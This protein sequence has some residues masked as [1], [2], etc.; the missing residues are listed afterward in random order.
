MKILQRTVIIP[1]VF[2][3]IA[4]CF[5]VSS[6]KAEVLPATNVSSIK[7]ETPPQDMTVSGNIPDPDAAPPDRSFR[8]EM[9]SDISP[10]SEKSTFSAHIEYSPE[11]YIVK[12]TFEEFPPDLNQ[13]LLLYSL[14]GKNWQVCDESWTLPSAEAA[15]G[16][17][18]KKLLDHTC[19]HSNTEPFKS[20]LAQNLDRFY[21]KL[22]YT[23]KDGNTWESREAVI[24]RGG[25]QP[26]PDDF[27][28]AAKFASSLLISERNPIG[29]YGRYQLTV[30]E[31]SLP[32]KI[33]SWLPD[34]LPVEI[35]L[36]QGGLFVT[37]CVIDCPVTWKPLSLPALT[38]G[39]SV[40]IYNAAEKIEIPAGTL[41][42][43]PTGVYRLDKPLH[44]DQFPLTDEVRLVLNVIDKESSPEGVLSIDNYGLT[45]SFHKK[46]T[47][48]T[49]I[50]VYLLT[51]GETEWTELADHSLSEAV[52]A[53]PITPNSGYALVLPDT[54]KPFQ[55][56][57]A[58][59][60]AG[61]APT[62]FYIGL[63]IEGGVYHG[64]ELI[65]PW[66]GTYDSDLL[67]LPNLSGS[68]GN[69]GNAGSDNK[70]DS[71]AEGQRP[72]LP[73]SPELQPTGSSDN[74]ADDGMYQDSP[75]SLAPSSGIPSEN[76]SVYED[77]QNPEID[78]ASTKT[79]AL[80]DNSTLFSTNPLSMPD[81]ESASS[82]VAG[83]GTNSDK[84][85]SD[86]ADRETD[87][88]TKLF[89]AAERT[90]GSVA[91]TA[92][93]GYL[94]AEMAP[95]SASAAIDSPKVTYFEET[96]DPDVGNQH[97][98]FPLLAAAVILAGLYLVGTGRR[99]SAKSR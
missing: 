39:D 18:S 43:T 15:D 65:L 85:S 25:P 24:D 81:S 2:V 20:Y 41:L 12:G 99:S 98:A 57:M 34:T 17:T 35:Q 90:S 29:Y 88:A 22:H 7:A 53:Q 97:Y 47:G 6:V 95:F 92:V 71:T 80:A 70:D 60:A 84:E 3:M 5:S 82:K 23:G 44:I 11:G 93:P 87:S 67:S 66:P 48:A 68:G 45:M 13:V 33:A 16:S 40:T 75:G 69:P 9:V 77:P 73:Q 38:A 94:P 42:H 56:Y 74:N 54:A 62:P 36:Q 76:R 10:F 26:L 86:V 58:A 4:G 28:P 52:N 61:T 50:H 59:Q 63:K 83:S 32:E 49:A 51:E 27:T 89:S 78:S 79:A 72:E 14:D 91:E 96:N 37:G 8:K 64:R 1:A 46:P 30:R 31:D 55:S 21:L 19:L